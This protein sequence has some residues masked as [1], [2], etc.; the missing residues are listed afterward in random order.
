MRHNFKKLAIWK[1]ARKF[2]SLIY[3]LT[4]KLPSS[5]RFGLIDQ[6]RRAAVSIPSNIA[7][8]C[9]RSTDKDLCRFLYIANGSLCE[10][11]T[12]L[13]LLSDLNYVKAEDLKE[14]ALELVEIRKMLQSFILTLS[15]SKSK[16]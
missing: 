10:L 14:I 13:Y 3:K 2:V 1:R 12:Q 15:S 11:E 4:D 16:A 7:E 5:E 8:G 9:G 6:M